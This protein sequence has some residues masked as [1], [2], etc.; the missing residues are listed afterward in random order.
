MAQATDVWKQRGLFRADTTAGI[1]IESEP[2]YIINNASKLPPPD[3]LFVL[4]HGGSH[5]REFV[6][7]LGTNPFWVRIPVE[8]KGSQSKEISVRLPNKGAETAMYTGTPFKEIKPV[9]KNGFVYLN[10]TLEPGKNILYIRHQQYWTKMYFGADIIASAESDNDRGEYMDIASDAVFTIVAFAVLILFQ[11]VYVAL[12]M[13]FHKKP[14]YFQYLLYLLCIGLYFEIRMELIVKIDGLTHFIPF[15]IPYLNDI[16]LL[17]PFTYYLGF[18]RYFIGTRELFPVMDRNIRRIEI[19]NLIMAG[20]VVLLMLTGFG[21]VAYSVVMGTVVVIFFISLWL[22]RFFYLRRNKLTQFLLLASL[23]AVTGHFLA[24]TIPMFPSLAAK[25]PFDLINI[26]MVGLAFE[27]FIFNTGLGYKAKHEQEEKLKA[28]MELISQYKKNQEIQEQMQGM[29]DKIAND[30]HDDI[31]ST[32]S[33]IVVYGQVA[34]NS[35]KAKADGILLKIIDSSQRMMES[36]RDIVWAIHSRNDEGKGMVKRMRD[37]A[38]ERLGLTGIKFNLETDTEVESQLFTMAARRN[39]LMLFKEALNNA[40]KHSGATIISCR[41]QISNG[42]LIL[43]ITDNG[44]GFDTNI[45][46]SGNGLVSMRQR[47]I[48]LKARL[49]VESS[50]E[51]GTC[52]RIEIPLAENRIPG[53]NAVT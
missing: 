18:S 22:I 32:L 40:V 38:S 8:V 36:M 6:L 28:Q 27:M 37:A 46:N 4:T 11:I 19:A 42:I 30:L 9:F 2:N 53:H 45:Q 16:L 26:T 33:G 12:Q 7:S 29:R 25:I 51:K 24:M 50:T 14:E 44:K 15:A 47:T 41:L 34:I 5:I 10:V 35:E 39:M 17:I 31:G 43:E 48:E 52:I 3:S 49:E 1:F 13:Y 20:V 23:F 21:K